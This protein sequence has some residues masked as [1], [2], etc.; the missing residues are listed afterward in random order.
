MDTHSDVRPAKRKATTEHI[1]NEELHF[2]VHITDSLADI[3]ETLRQMTEAMASLGART[4]K[5]EE[6]AG[7]VRAKKGV[8][9]LG[10]SRATSSGEPQGSTLAESAD[11]SYDGCE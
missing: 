6:E 9:T 4:S 1:R 2:R 8:K 7:K 3:K 10:K 5:L 11:L